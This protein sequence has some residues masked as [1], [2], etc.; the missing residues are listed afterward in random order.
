MRVYDIGILPKIGGTIGCITRFF[1]RKKLDVAGNGSFPLGNYYRRPESNLLDKS[2]FSIYRQLVNLTKKTP[3]R[4]VFVD[5]ND[6]YSAD[7]IAFNAKKL[8]SGLKEMGISRGDKVALMAMPHERELYESVFALQA[9]GAVPVLIN[10]LNTPNV[11]YM[12]L[13]SDCKAL[14]VGRHPGMQ[15]GAEKAAKRG[16][17]KHVIYVDDKDSNGSWVK[18]LFIPYSLAM[19]RQPPLPDDELMIDPPKDYP[20]L[21]LYTSG[22]EGRPKR[23][24]YSYQM[25]ADVV[26]ALE[27]FKIDRFDKVI[28]P[29]PFYHLAGL[30]IFSG[31]L[32]SEAPIIL[33]EIPRKSV[34]ETIPQTLQKIIQN[35]VTIFPG[36]PAILE[37]VLELALEKQETMDKLRLIFSGAAPLTQNLVEL[38]NELNVR[39]IN[40]GMK[41]IQLVNLYASTECGPISSTVSKITRDNRSSVGIPFDGVGVKI[42]PESELL[43][44]PKTFP[45]DLPKEFLTEDGFFKTGDFVEL[46][47]NNEIVFR[48]RQKERLNIKGEKISPD[49]IQNEINKLPG[50]R[51]CYVFGVEKGEG[52]ESDLVCALVIPKIKDDSTVTYETIKKSLKEKNL[53]PGG[54]IPRVI[55][56][57]NSVPISVMG[58]TGKITCASLAKVYGDRARKIYHPHVK[59]GTSFA[60]AA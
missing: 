27:R 57:E 30:I 37:P 14:I 26:K 2:K 19:N 17:F 51:D 52:D 11:P 13:N 41:P 1:A 15:K 20:A 25:V 23:M 28:L 49:T 32:Q 42:S 12:F 16:L 59:E 60:K 56:V 47:E 9:I 43:V 18:K 29:V 35:E 4:I 24:T 55:F 34:P 6:Q 33:T 54:L 31:A 53:L 48:S 44:K 7:D 3:K 38:V 45:L 5:G 22:S 39:R 8:A 40:K 10:F 36:V 58:T 21:Q 50:V 46:G